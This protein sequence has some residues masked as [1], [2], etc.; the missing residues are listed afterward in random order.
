MSVQK[1]QSG[2]IVKPRQVNIVQSPQSKI[3]GSKVD[4]K[5]TE[6]TSNSRGWTPAQS[7]PGDGPQTPEFPTANGT[8]GLVSNNELFLP[9]VLPNPQIDTS[10]MIK[11]LMSRDALLQV[12]DAEHSAKDAGMRDEL[13]LPFDVQSPE[14]DINFMMENLLLRDAQS[15]GTAPKAQETSNASLQVKIEPNH[16]NHSLCKRQNS[17]SRE[18]LFQVRKLEPV[19]KK[20][21]KGSKRASTVLQQ[22]HGVL[23]RRDDKKGGWVINDEH[24]LFRESQ[25]NPRKNE[26]RWVAASVLERSWGR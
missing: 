6:T 3:T 5:V 21:A 20:E 23:Y 25:K 24:F 12:P 4:M 14:I 2:R 26:A 19:Q 22:I 17:I 13:F 1:A 7:L 8:E 10:F 9:F 11:E 18:S 15:Q 16:D